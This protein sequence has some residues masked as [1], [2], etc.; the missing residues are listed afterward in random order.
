ML[1][2]H[3]AFDARK[4]LR[5]GSNQLVVRVIDASYAKEVD[6][7]RLGDVPGGRQH[8][9]PLEEGFRH[10]NYGGL[11]LPVTAQGFASPWIGDGFI[12]PDIRGSKIDVDL[13]I[14]G[15]NGP[16]EW[17]VVVRPIYPKSGQA[18]VDRAV[19]VTPNADGRSTI[20]VDIPNAHLW[21]VSGQFSL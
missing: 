6:G 3:F 5:P 7:F 11:L 12:R 9:N 4:A 8:D 10:E 14:I 2:C 17:K 21:R 18:V 20:S 19:L 15:A 1:C 16:A 13:R